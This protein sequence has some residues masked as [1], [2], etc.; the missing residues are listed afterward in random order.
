MLQVTSVLR[1]LKRQQM[2][3]PHHQPTLQLPS[4]VL[5]HIHE[6]PHITHGL[7]ERTQR[8]GQLECLDQPFHGIVRRPWLQVGIPQ[9]RANMGFVLEDAVI[10]DRVNDGRQLKKKGTLNLSDFVAV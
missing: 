1:P 7:M 2:P 10:K 4:S 5:C 9:L 8:G 6:N 3:E